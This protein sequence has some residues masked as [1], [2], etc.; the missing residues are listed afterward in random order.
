MDNLASISSKNFIIEAG[1]SIRKVRHEKGLSLE[2]L[3]NEI[4]V[5]RL[6][7]SKIEKGEA[8]PTINIMWKICEALS[9]PFAQLFDVNED[10]KL[11]RA[12]DSVGIESDDKSFR[13]ELIFR[14][15][16]STTTEFYR[17]YL[18]KGGVM[19]T[20]EHNRGTVEIATVMKGE[21]SINIGDEEF[22]LKEY[23]SLKFKADRKHS[24]KN[25]NDD[26]SVIHMS[27]IYKM[28]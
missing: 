15:D 1:K 23:D 18:S 6:T 28:I 16:S 12:N 20:E 3:S 7:L 9:I 25:L 5:S 8:N 21:I 24:Y 14:E 19:F 11:S 22:I 2:E 4:N 13:I 10:I 27:V 26:E 17:T